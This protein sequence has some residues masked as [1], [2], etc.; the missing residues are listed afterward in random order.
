MLSLIP[1]GL[2]ITLAPHIKALCPTDHMSDVKLQDPASRFKPGTYVKC[3]VSTRR[4]CYGH[5]DERVTKPSFARS[6]IQMR[7]KEKFL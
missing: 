4:Q 3:R 2:L 7:R 1:A 5:H 6:W